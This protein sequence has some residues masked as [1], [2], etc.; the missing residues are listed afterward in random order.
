MLGVVIPVVLTA[1]AYIVKVEQRFA[2]LNAK[3]DLLLDNF[4]IKRDKK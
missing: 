4:H 2:D 3:V 1:L